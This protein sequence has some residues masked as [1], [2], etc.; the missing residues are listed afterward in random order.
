MYLIPNPKSFEKQYGNFLLKPNTEIILDS[1]CSFDDLESA[2]ILQE[3]I[4][5]AVGVKLSINKAF[6]NKDNKNVIVLSKE[7][8]N[9]ESY[10]LNINDN[11]IFINGGDSAGLFYGV[12][13]LRQIIRQSGNRILALDIEDEPY[14]LNR[15]FYHDVTRG[16]VPT[17][18][19]LKELVDRAAFY[20]INQL[21]LYI[22][23]TFAF[24]NMSEVWMDKD[25]LKAEEILILDEYA[26][27][28]H[29]ELIPSL[30]TF[31]H[32]YEVLSTKSFESLCELD[33][34]GYTEHSFVSRMEH[35]TL[36]VN[37]EGS[38]KLVEK[39]IKEY[40]PLFTSNKFN[41]CCD[42]TFDLGKGK[43]KK[44]AEKE[45]V[46]KLYI[47]FLNKV[48]DVVKES[49]KQV[50]FWGDIILRHTDV[51]NEIPKDTICLN[52]NYGAEAL[53]D[54]TKIIAE[55]GMEQYV[56]PGVSGWNR[57]MN[58]MDFAFTNI[59]K[60]IDYGKKYNVSGVLNTDWGDF[61][62]INLLSASIPGMAY[63]G[64]L[65]W[66]PNGE[67]DFFVFDKAFSKIEYEDSTESIMS[68]LRELSNAH[69]ANWGHLV[70][71]KER[72]GTNEYLK[73]EL[74]KMKVK[75]LKD[76]AKKAIKIQE[77]LMSLNQKISNHK[78]DLKEFII[79]SK[80]IE[81]IN[82]AFI[83]ILEDDYNGEEHIDKKERYNLAEEFELWFYNYSFIWR[84]RNKESE[85]SKIGEVI[86]Y[87]CKYLRK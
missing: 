5:K 87:L 20:K 82:K 78:F 53:E 64:A 44:I 60:M 19:T 13:T 56:C 17:L 40:I 3:E 45:G 12:Q 43:N 79:S 71:W 14:F 29:V 8:G 59:R 65:S 16:K 33:E 18:K 30:S 7:K 15:G 27:K 25:P 51:I 38:I 47:K 52:W 54:G 50:M 83:V 63:G 49:G 24:K 74:L 81:L 46:G 32:L 84:E 66:N 26:K 42:E 4:E 62:H 68:L 61:G 21:Q 72:Y 80:G 41:I 23:H 22:E 73:E 69:I 67:K 28:R 10:K 76:G 70:I 2:L 6:L 1:N 48:I 39:M 75:D 34:T 86:K 55:S 57:L 77:V 31:G 9:K 85:L 35:H 36:D 58:H 37:N 11:G